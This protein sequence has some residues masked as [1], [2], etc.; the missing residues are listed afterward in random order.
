MSTFDVRS[1]TPES[2][3]NKNHVTAF[4]ASFLDL[5]ITEYPQCKFPTGYCARKYVN[6]MHQSVIVN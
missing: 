1:C 6:S 2:I 4:M 5:R 3:S